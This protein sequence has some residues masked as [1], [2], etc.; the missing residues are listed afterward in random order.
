METIEK[1][2][3]AQNLPF[4]KISKTDKAVTRLIK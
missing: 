4:E 3:K 1:I 2:D